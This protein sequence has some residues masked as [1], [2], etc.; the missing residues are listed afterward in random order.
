M[1]LYDLVCSCGYSKEQVLKLNEKEPMCD[2]CGLKMVK[3]M[4]T[5]AFILKGAG[6]SKDNYGLK[7]SPKKSGGNKNGA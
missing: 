3:A 7:S 1:P 4:S 5:P 2:K 6:W